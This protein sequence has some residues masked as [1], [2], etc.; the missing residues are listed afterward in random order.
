VLELL[1]LATESERA[2]AYHPRHLVRLGA[3]AGLT[4]LETAIGP[5]AARYLHNPVFEIEVADGARLQHGRLQH[6]GT[7]GVFLSTVYARVAAGATYDNFTLNAGARLARNEIHV[8]LTGPRAEAHM[9]G[10]QLVGD[11][12]HADTITPRRIAAAARP[13]RRCWS[14]ARAASSRARSTSTRSRRRP[15]ATR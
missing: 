4:I 9:N 5:A 2:P 13:T 8:A 7:E 15:T 14:A 3:G 11:G 6:E 1:S 10:V 12:Q